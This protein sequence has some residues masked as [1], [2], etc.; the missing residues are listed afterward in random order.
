MAKAITN[1]ILAQDIA[2]LKSEVASSHDALR[3]QLDAGYNLILEKLKP[4]DELRKAQE[5]TAA[6]VAAHSRTISWMRGVGATVS[7][8][9][10][11]FLGILTYLKASHK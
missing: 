7:A 11:L 6:E 5:K 1:T 2:V 10:T 4:L 8:V 9:F 3:Q